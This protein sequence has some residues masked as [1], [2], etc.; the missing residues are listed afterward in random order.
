MQHKIPSSGPSQ[1]SYKPF[2]DVFIPGE[3]RQKPVKSPNI[4]YESFANTNLEI[5]EVS[6]VTQRPLEPAI[7]ATCGGSSCRGG[8]SVAQRPLEPACATCAQRHALTHS[9]QHRQELVQSPHEHPHFPSKAPPKDISPPTESTSTIKTIPPTQSPQS[10]PLP[11]Q[12]FGLGNPTPLAIAAFSVT[13]TTLSFALM[14]W[15]GVTIQNV[16]VANFIFYAGITMLITAQW[17]LVLGRSF[18][19]LV[20]SS[21]GAFYLG[22]GAIITPSL[23]VNASYPADGVMLYNAYGFYL[24]IWTVLVGLLMIGTLRTN[25]VFILIFVLVW[26]GFVLLSIS[27]FCLADGNLQGAHALRLVSGY[28]CFITGLLGFYLLT[29]Q[30]L[31]IMGF[32]ITLPLGVVPDNYFKFNKKKQ[33]SL[34]SSG[35]QGSRC[36]CDLVLDAQLLLQD[37][38]SR[39]DEGIQIPADHKERGSRSASGE[40]GERSVWT[41]VRKSSRRENSVCIPSGKRLSDF[42]RPAKGIPS[43]SVLA[44]RPRRASPLWGRS[45]MMQTKKKRPGRLEI[46]VS[47][48]S[49]PG[50][51]PVRAATSAEAFTDW[52]RHWLTQTKINIGIVGSGGVGK[53]FLANILLESTFEERLNH[54]PSRRSSF[55]DWE[56]EEENIPPYSSEFSFDEQYMDDRF[57]QTFNWQSEGEARNQRRQYWHSNTIDTTISDRYSFLLPQGS[58]ESYYRDY[59]IAY[60][61]RACLFYKIM[62]CNSIGQFLYKLHSPEECSR[63]SPEALEVLRRYY[64]QILNLKRND[65]APQP[66]LLNPDMLADALPDEVKRISGRVM[67]FRGK[68]MN[69][70]V[71]RLYVR[72]RLLEAIG[73][74]APIVESFYIQLPCSVLKGNRQLTLYGPVELAD[75]FGYNSQ[76]KNTN[77]MI[78]GLDGRG[79]MEGTLRFL[80]NTS[81]LNKFVSKNEEHKMLFAALTERGE[82]ESPQAATQILEFKSRHQVM[83]ARQYIVSELSRELEQEEGKMEVASPHNSNSFLRGSEEEAARNRKRAIQSINLL[84]CKP[85]LFLSIRSNASTTSEARNGISRKFTCS[86]TEVEQRTNLPAV[87]ACIQNTVISKCRNSLHEFNNSWML[88]MKNMKVTKANILEISPKSMEQERTQATNSTERLLNTFRE[89]MNAWRT[90]LNDTSANLC[91]YIKT[92]AQEVNLRRVEMNSMV[93]PVDMYMEGIRAYWTSKVVGIISQKKEEMTLFITGILKQ[94]SKLIKLPVDVAN[95][96]E[97]MKLLQMLKFCTVWVDKCVRHK[98]EEFV[99]SLMRMD[100]F[101]ITSNGGQRMVTLGAQRQMIP[102][103]VVKRLST[104]LTSQLTNGLAAYN[105][106]QKASEH[107]IEW[108]LG[109]PYLKSSQR[110]RESVEMGPAQ[111]AFEIDQLLQTPNALPSTAQFILGFTQVTERPTPFSVHLWESLVASRKARGGSD[112]N[113]AGQNTERFVQQLKEANL[114]VVDSTPSFGGEPKNSQF[115][116]FSYLVYGSEEGANIVRLLLMNEIL[117]KSNTFVRFMSSRYE[118]E[119]TRDNK[120]SQEG[121]FGQSSAIPIVNSF[122]SSLSRQR[123]RS[124]S[125]NARWSNTVDEYVYD[126]SYDDEEGDMITLL[127]FCH[128]YNVDLFIYSPDFPRPILVQ[129]DSVNTMGDNNN[130]AGSPPSS[131]QRQTF[132]LALFQGKSFQPL[133]KRAQAALTD[134]D[135]DRELG[136]L[137][138]LQISQEEETMEQGNRGRSRSRLNSGMSLHRIQQIETEDNMEEDTEEVNRFTRIPVG[139]VKKLS[140]LCVELVCR[141]IEEMPALE[142]TLPEDMTQ[143]ILDRLLDR[144]QLDDSTIEKCVYPFLQTLS[145]DNYRNFSLTTYNILQHNGSYLRKL[146]LVNCHTVTSIDFV[147]TVKYLGN[148]TELSLEGCDRIDDEALTA[149]AESC[150]KLRSLDVSSCLKITHIGLQR[151]LQC[152]L[153]LEKLYS[154]NNAIADPFLIKN[155]LSLLHLQDCHSLS[156]HFLQ[157]VAHTCPRLSSLRV[158][159]HTVN[160]QSIET[161]VQ[162]CPTITFL[163]IPESEALND[164]AVHFIFRLE[165]LKSLSIQ[166][167]KNVTDAGLSELLHAKCRHTLTGL[168]LTRCVKLTGDTIRS[169]ANACRG[170]SQFSLSAISEMTM[171]EELN[172]DVLASMVN[173]FAQLTRIDLS[174]CQYVDDSVVSLLS[175]SSP[176]LTHVNLQH[177]TRITDLSLA[178]ISEGC[179]QLICLTLNSC[180]RITD[181]GLSSIATRCHEVKTL[182]LEECTITD[183]GICAVSLGCP[184][185]ESINLA[186]VKD[187]VTDKSLHYLSRCGDMESVDFSYS[188]KITTKGIADNMASWP[189]LRSLQLKGFVNV[190]D[191]GFKHKNL[192]VL[193][194]SWCKTLTDKGLQSI[195]EGCP[196]LESLVL[197]W[198][199]QVTSKAIHDLTRTTPH[200]RQLNI[201]GCSR[202]SVLMLKFLSSNGVITR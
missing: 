32:G 156:Q 58:F 149:L 168:H 68:G 10:I 173:K 101:Q 202:V 198:C 115:R 35:S 127:A 141:Y 179:P 14:E 196:G 104:Q 79:L 25:L 60:G 184:S 117:S 123:P 124:S 3:F 2:F 26:I 161:L 7:C 162:L 37:E 80:R 174:G 34:V 142:G 107:A 49:P 61:K 112:P 85:L 40:K 55:F 122:H 57:G 136:K 118:E 178:S 43:P 145:L 62:S 47:I 81:F 121:M 19:Y 53:S 22:F 119:E 147:Q 193:N 90:E 185:L 111:E 27:F 15:R 133:V 45:E 99:T 175:S 20:F 82:V 154:N 171:S 103:N 66:Q 199:I 143:A 195:V 148:L 139:A 97:K 157:L 96:Q 146:S 135:V 169:I 6:A 13:L 48:G 65:P 73:R 5:M 89:K 4:Q 86:T 106:I 56:E 140:T 102:D 163:D 191:L 30:I 18:P 33:A 75:L 166:G 77:L 12:A 83:K 129:P 70:D 151:V 172:S 72:E 152:C 197:A 69:M 125:G 176:Q 116:A 88:K 100:L 84:Y 50:L 158:P 59:T 93:N 28:F 41:Y 177:C 21:F 54:T 52:L 134:M 42:S 180:D 105:S 132:G 11:P 120:E 165:D 24:T 74:H 192:R 182:L 51:N 181:E 188:K 108:L 8:C 71:D 64:R 186:H 16:F 114:E 150:P 98:T 187:K 138:R 76:A 109:T 9:P 167:A 67:A 44:E 46:P 29:A 17:E 94:L 160:S 189:R 183:N 78:V 194:L 201:R 110:S 137:N 159:G 39:D 164:Q 31:D 23:G 1:T 95:E 92:Q 130:N 128:F 126:M 63:L 131:S 144:G 91:A 190:S 155:N 87:L 153:G 170:L 36:D 113:T 200:L 38:T